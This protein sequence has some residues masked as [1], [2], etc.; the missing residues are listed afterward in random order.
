[1]KKLAKAMSVVLALTMITGLFAAC[2]NT[3]SGT[4]SGNKKTGLNPDYSYEKTEDAW[5]DAKRD[6]TMT[7]ADR[8]LML[9]ALQATV[10]AYYH[11]NPY[12]QYDES[13]MSKE[14]YAKSF[15]NTWEF[16]PEYGSYDQSYYSVCNT[17][18]AALLLDTFGYSFTRQDGHPWI[19]AE[20]K[21]MTGP[22]VV[23]TSQ[24]NTEDMLERISKEVAAVVQPGDMVVGFGD[25]GH[26]MMCVGDIFG[27]G[28]NYFT[29]CWGGNIN[30]DGTEKHE[31]NGS[32]YIQTGEDVL[33]GPNLGSPNWAITK[34]SHSSQNVMVYRFF[35]DPNFTGKI[36][37]EAMSRM[38]YPD[39]VIDKRTDVMK[40]NTVT[41]GQQITLTVEVK[42]TGKEDYKDVEI[43][44][45]LPV[46]T[47]LVSGD[48]TA[49]TD[50]PAGEKFEMT[51]VLEVT[52]TP[53]KKVLFSAGRVDNIDTR[54][55][56][57]TVASSA[58][59]E[60]AAAKL[61]ATAEKVTSKEITAENN[62]DLV[63]AIYKDAF[64]VDLDLPGTVK[65]YLNLRFNKKDYQGYSFLDAKPVTDEIKTLAA[66]EPDEMFGGVYRL[67]DMK[68]HERM[69]D[70]MEGYFMPGDILIRMDGENQISDNQ[71]IMTRVYVCL[72]DGMALAMT[73]GA[74][75]IDSVEGAIKT[76]YISNQFIVLRP[77]LIY[78]LQ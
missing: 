13:N 18:M 33:F 35:D 53:G 37:P 25:T 71:P 47:K 4:D 15:R 59:N 55:M 9:K 48:L 57:Y 6:E 43:E 46:G 72:G 77:A 36:T 61:T 16:G 78:N 12:C 40:Y 22:A 51:A 24:V 20:F 49:K 74:N 23:Y 32:I 7:E 56:S 70:V 3:R 75:K 14:G 30:D 41:T 42:N 39:M 11:K 76:F 17:Y 26:V 63:K 28:K 64:G 66:M 45:T 52:E 44:E 34:L 31:D 62:L 60:E 8:D 73:K 27:D 65:D 58:M 10:L 68:V 19:T 5:Q 2:G 29:H 67:C 69:L 54:R 21:N 38:K 1:M 50:I